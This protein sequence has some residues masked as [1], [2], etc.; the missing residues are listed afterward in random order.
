MTRRAIAAAALVGVLA[1]PTLAAAQPLELD[2]VEFF[3]PAVDRT[4]KYNIVLP[5]APSGTAF[6]MVSDC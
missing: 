1:M 3:S 5:P 6:K 4:M 2:T